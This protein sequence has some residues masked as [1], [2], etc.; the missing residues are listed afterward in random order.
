MNQR[1]RLAKA[2]ADDHFSECDDGC[3]FSEFTDGIEY[4]ERLITYGVRVINEEILQRAFLSA[5]LGSYGYSKED[6]RDL[7]A[8]IDKES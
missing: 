2:I 3:G 1:D 7:L 8:A 4:A 5:K 6:A